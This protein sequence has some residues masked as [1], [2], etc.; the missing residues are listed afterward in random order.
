M[1]KKKFF[2]FFTAPIRGA[3]GSAGKAASLRIL[4]KEKNAEQNLTHL[5]TSFAFQG[6]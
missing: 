6:F 5:Q 3:N 4:E 2:E 1:T